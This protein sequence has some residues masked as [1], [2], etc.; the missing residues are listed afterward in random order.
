MAEPQQPWWMTKPWW[1]VTPQANDLSTWPVLAPLTALSQGSM[2]GGPNWVPGL[3]PL[4]APLFGANDAL[5]RGMANA[6]ANTV[7][8]LTANPQ[9]PAAKA[10]AKQ[11]A[12]PTDPS[13]FF[14]MPQPLQANQ[15]QFDIGSYVTQRIPGATITSDVRSPEKN[16]E[17]GGVA[18]SQHLAANGGWARDFI[19]P[20]GKTIAQ[21][22]A[23]ITATLPPGWEAIKESDHV[24]VERKSGGDPWQ[25]PNVSNTMMDPR[26]AANMIPMPGPA[27]TIGLKD[28]AQIPTLPDKPLM[29]DIP[30][31]EWIASMAG[32]APKGRDKSKDAGDRITQVIAGMS[33]GAASVDAR[34]GAGAVLAAMGAGASQAAAT[35]QQATRQEDKADAEA[36]RLFAL[37][38]AREKINLQGQ[39]RGVVD[40]NNETKWQN[41]RAGMITRYENEQSKIDTENKEMLLNNGIQRDWDSEMLQARQ[42]RARTALGIME[43]NAALLRD[44]TLGQ[45]QL[46]LKRYLYEDEKSTKGIGEQAA[47]IVQGIATGVGIDY[48][49][50]IANK[51][52]T[53]MNALQG[54]HYMAAQNKPAA[55]NSLAREMILTGHY[56]SLITDPTLLKQ[57]EVVAA[58]DPELASVMLGAELNKE[59]MGTPGAV[60]GLANVMS[61]YG[62]P[63]ATAFSRLGKPTPVGTNTGK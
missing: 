11:T 24:H 4:L 52:V 37:S 3:S 30:V 18:N 12:A 62:T 43:T 5:G 42:L 1:Q 29:A 45:A 20:K 41:Q 53:A 51:D 60:L 38:L 31:D 61:A 40:K 19:P 8:R 7:Q 58:R 59:E 34:S 63:M 50:A 33:A 47:A 48:K 13:T 28:P 56:K 44:Q 10:P 39:Q 21:L 16:K 6:G 54:F 25:M 57:V 9:K 22:H 27:R 36:Q 35:W 46:D 23:D 32:Y 15:Q 14:Q 49:T 17:V 26:A 2:Q 55:I